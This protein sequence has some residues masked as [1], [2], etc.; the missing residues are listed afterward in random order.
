MERRRH[1]RG[2]GPPSRVKPDIT[3]W[4]HL[5]DLI[6]SDGT[7][8]IGHVAPLTTCTAIAAQGRQVYAMLAVAEDETLT[9]LLD[10]LDTAV[11]KALEDGVYT[12]EI[13]G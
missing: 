5:Q 2:K 10:R 11:E 8:N 7:I 13:N 1:G 6:D 12:D 3:S 4:P 9:S